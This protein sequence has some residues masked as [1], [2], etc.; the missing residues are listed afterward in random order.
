MNL[1]IIGDCHGKLAKYHKII[2]QKDRH[3]YTVQIG[4]LTIG[5]NSLDTLKNVDHNCHRVLFGNHDQYP[6]RHKYPHILGDYGTFSLGGFNN[7]FY[8]RGAWSIDYFYRTPQ[9]DW[10]EEEQVPFKEFENV[11]KAYLES[12]PE[13]FLAHECPAFLVHSYL[14][15]DAPVFNTTTTF[16]LEELWKLHQPKMFIHG[17][18]HLSRKTK[19]GNTTFVCL[20]E[21]E[22]FKIPSD[23]GV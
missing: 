5:R 1:T 3:P 15:T 20:D 7:I 23:F 14:P 22:I 4:D 11:K 21:L 18:Y 13:L 6:D 10:F 19:Y 12:K 17:H 2:S 9:V 8:Y 16:V